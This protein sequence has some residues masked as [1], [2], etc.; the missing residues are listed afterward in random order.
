MNTGIQDAYNLAF[1]LSYIAKN[2]PDKSQVMRILSK[3]TEERRSHAQS[4]LSVAMRYYRNSLNIADFLGITI[5]LL[6]I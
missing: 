3:Y 4:N 6:Y 1:K 5:G 2:N